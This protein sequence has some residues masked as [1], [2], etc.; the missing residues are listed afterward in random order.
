VV[1]VALAAAELWLR[2][3]GFARSD[4]AAGGPS[5]PPTI[6]APERP[7]AAPLLIVGGAFTEARALPDDLRWSSRLAQRVVGATGFSDL[8]V[9]APLAGPGPVLQAALPALAR[10]ADPPS[11]RGLNVV[12]HDRGA[13][14]IVI[15]AG[16]DA[17]GGDALPFLIGLPPTA[18]AAPA[19]DRHGLALLNW[20]AQWRDARAHADDERA[21]ELLIASDGF[22]AGAAAGARRR[23]EELTA[24]VSARR[25]DEAQ[26]RFLRALIGELYGLR[27]G[28]V[29]LQAIG[30]WRR[31]FGA[32]RMEQRSIL[33][34]LT[35]PSLTQVALLQL[36]MDLAIPI[37]HAP[38][39]DL[40]PRLRLD[41][42]GADAA[43]AVH[44]EVADA[45][46]AALT[47]R[48][49]LPAVLHAPEGVIELSDQ[50][51]AAARARGGIDE[52]L[53]VLA[54]GCLT[55]RCELGATPPPEALF[56]IG[57]HGRLTPG[58]AAELVL[59]QPSLPDE[60]VVRASV[61]AGGTPPRLKIRHARGELLL[62]PRVVAPAGKAERILLE[63]RGAAPSTKDVVV[64]PAYEFTLAT[65]ANAADPEFELAVVELTHKLN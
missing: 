13:D 35:G 31:L 53:I 28:E 33:L 3:H 4:P 51:E 24:A 20:F 12:A 47:H 58:V 25:P 39:F 52:S 26:T 46:W 59:K 62:E 27:R 38:P 64:R 29:R 56:G 48:G 16:G 63:Y 41:H 8:V 60:L 45:V 18:A 21:L 15:E 23:L 44:A 50:I 65:A 54:N 1:L 34:V 42:G 55:E 17:L 7:R 5:R 37:V 36:A 57:A 22:V 19:P 11:A 32:L 49:I 61:K 10:T 30:E 14:V 2:A 40:D 6:T 9:A 43:A